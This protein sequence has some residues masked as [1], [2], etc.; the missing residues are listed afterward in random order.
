[1]TRIMSSSKLMR[2]WRG[3]I[4]LSVWA[5]TLSG[6][7]SACERRDTSQNRIAGEMAELL[8]EWRARDGAKFYELTPKLLEACLLNPD[9]FYG[10]M[11][12]DSAAFEQFLDELRPACF[13]NLNDTA[14]T[15]L[16][17]YRLQTMASV[18]S[19][20]IDPR[21]RQM[22]ERLLGRLRDIRARYI[23]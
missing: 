12:T 13:T 10:A 2:V 9:A 11:V 17:E 15:E 8:Q 16:E 3:I 20:K 18:E 6:L 5:A 19:Q 14:I 21:Y 23:E 1:M 22:K 7:N 4:I